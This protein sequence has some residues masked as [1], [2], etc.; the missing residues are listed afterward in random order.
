MKITE[1]EAGNK[2]ELNH[3]LKSFFGLVGQECSAAVSTYMQTHNVLYRGFRP[4]SVGDR[5]LFK[6][7]P[8]NNRKTMS[9]NSG[10]QT[11]IDDALSKCGFTALRSNS[12]FCTSDFS[13]ADS[14]GKPYIIFPKNG[15]KFTWSPE[16][17]D[18][19]LDLSRTYHVADV[20][21]L[22]SIVGSTDPRAIVD[23]FKF[24]NQM[25]IQAIRSHN[26]ILI[27]GEYYAVS[28]EDYELEGDYKFEVMERYISL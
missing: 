4:S 20:N 17:A 10:I 2:E 16:I 22:I 14:Y 15:F 9:I 7:N 12:L 19:F 18:L 24:T 26:E 5:T 28:V 21:D 25:F 13:D 8:R 23:H 1:I 3:T 11:V 6:G 27:S